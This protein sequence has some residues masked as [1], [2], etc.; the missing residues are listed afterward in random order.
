MHEG[1]HRAY[2]ARWLARETLN[3]GVPAENLHGTKPSH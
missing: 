1:I 3:L 2:G